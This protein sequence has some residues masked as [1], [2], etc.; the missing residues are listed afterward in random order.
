LSSDFS[1]PCNFWVFQL[2]GQLS[3]SLVPIWHTFFRNSAY[4]ESLSELSEHL[5]IMSAIFKIFTHWF[6]W[7]IH[8]VQSRSC[9]RGSSTGLLECRLSPLF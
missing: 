5:L 1:V 7:I 3:T 2:H 4:C 6:S 8:A 9:E